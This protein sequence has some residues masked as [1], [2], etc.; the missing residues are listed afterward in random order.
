MARQSLLV[1]EAQEAPRLAVAAQ[2]V[3]V[4][5]AALSDSEPSALD[6]PLLDAARAG[7]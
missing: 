4:Q 1:V 2:Q 6:A 7:G 5:V 3:K